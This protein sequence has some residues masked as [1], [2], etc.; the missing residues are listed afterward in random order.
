[1]SN[2]LTP[3]EAAQFCRTN[4]DDPLLLQLLDQ[5]DR[6]VQYATGRDWTQDSAV[7]PIAKTA[8]QI[9]LVNWYD[10][11]SQ[12][13]TSPNGAAGPL[14]QLEAEALKYRKYQIEGI[15]GSGSVYLPGALEGDTVVAVTGVYGVSG[16]QSAL[17]ES[18]I[19]SDGAIQQ[20]DNGD[21]SEHLF[22][23]VLKSPSEDVVV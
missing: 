19:S 9:L 7:N 20:T 12:M 2:I 10:D 6:Y 15:S 21:H 18:A 14:V 11:P 23:V 13:G 4:A 16:D 1:M 5:V 22:V 17:F 3:N 8:A